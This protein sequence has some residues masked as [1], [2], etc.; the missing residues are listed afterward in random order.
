MRQYMAEVN[1]QHQVDLFWNPALLAPTGLAWPVSSSI[2]CWRKY[3]SHRVMVNTVTIHITCLTGTLVPC[4]FQ[5]FILAS[6]TL[7]CAL[8]EPLDCCCTRPAAWRTRPK[9]VFGVLRSC[10]LRASGFHMCRQIEH[11][12]F[13][14]RQ[15]Y[16][17]GAHVWTFLNLEGGS[18]GF[19]RAVSRPQLEWGRSQEHQ[20]ELQSAVWSEMKLP[21]PPTT[22]VLAN[23]TY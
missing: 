8:P 15:G 13:A 21:P 2:K 3:L 17:A 12:H 18:S 20:L 4:K 6:V 14:T 9:S 22:K 23:N 16:L 11:Y 19:Q 1:Y 10:G 7:S 5:L